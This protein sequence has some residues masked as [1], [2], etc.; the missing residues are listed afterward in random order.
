MT[1]ML[2]KILAR[3]ARRRGT[4]RIARMLAWLGI[5]P[6][7]LLAPAS[8]AAAGAGGDEERPN[9]VL[10]VW[11]D[12]ALESIG[13]LRPEPAQASATPHLDALFAGGTR[14]VR[15]TQVS[16]RGLPTAAAALT[17]RLPHRS[18]VYYHLASGPVAVE[19][20]LARLLREAGWATLCVGRSPLGPPADS[21]FEREARSVLASGSAAVVRFVED[22][23]GKQPLFLWWAPELADGGGARELDRALGDLVEALAARGQRE[24]TLFA[25]V[26]GG[27]PQGREFSAQECGAERMRNPLAFAGVGR[28]PGEKIR[29]GERA[30]LVTPLDLV[31]TLLDWLG[32][33]IPAGIDGRSLRPLVEGKP[34]EA[35]ALGAGFFPRQPSSGTKVPREPG[36]DLLALVLQD[37]RWKYVLYLRDIGI[38]VDP[39]TERVAIERSAGD[40]SLFDLEADPREEQDLALRSEHAAHL[41]ALRAAAVEW[42]RSSDGP[43]FPMPFL[44]PPLGPPPAEPRPNIVLVVADDMDHEHLGFLGNPRVKTPTLDELARTGVVFPVAHVPMSRCRPSLAA[45]L[46]GRWPQQCGIFDNESTHTLARRDSLPN[47]LKAAGYAT[48]QGGK[49]WEGSPLSMG[50]LEPRMTDTVFKSFVRQSQA[51]LFAF[52]DRYHAERPLFLWWAPMLPHGPFDPPERLRALFRETEVPV[53][54]G[55]VGDA[56][57]FQEAERTAYAMGAW[58]DEGLG[59]LRVKLEETGELADTLF[60]FLIDNGYANGSPSKGSVFEKGLRTPVV[61]AWP[62]GIQGGRTRPELVSSLDLYPTLLGYAG[63]PV[64]AGIPGI[65]LRPALEGRELETRDVLYGAV[66][67]YEEGARRQRAEDAVYAL[68][69]RT[70]R[71][72]FVLHLRRLDPKKNLLIHEFAPFPARA[73]GDRDLYD[74]E[75][76]PHERRDL[77]GDSSHAQLM[78]ELQQ[79]CLA[80][81]R[82]SGGGELDLPAGPSDNPG[83]K[84]PRR[85]QQDG[86]KQ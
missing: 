13:F 31:P 5:L 83:P 58:L 15:G 4:S 19:N 61:F 78:D 18:G 57:A 64:P 25:F 40:Q 54:P 33:P 53:P 71:W 29:A 67:E 60:V 16:A 76:D 6:F 24:R 35:R 85:K 2:E 52:I 11:N 34:L 63:V 39:V 70:P 55:I 45:L 28:I 36:R 56:Q 38:D 12:P 42:W 80:W 21:G 68:Y 37:G 69:A 30:E 66:Y 62:K 46:S 50:F 72:K 51:E 82:A 44:S 3:G 73:R 27:D 43:S 77:A 84:K 79:G 26:T 1:R 23:A 65:D 8:A 47:L 20:S 17:G 49:F 74:L 10:I 9:V 48:F 14:F 32:L 75:Q 59:A 81:W 41:A 22:F 7:L 86:R